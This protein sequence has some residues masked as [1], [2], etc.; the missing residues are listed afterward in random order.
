MNLRDLRLRLRAL[1]ARRRVERELAEELT[2]HIERDVHERVAEGLTREDAL[3]LA[4]S[5]FG[6]T[7]LVA[8]ACR[9]ARGTAFL[10]D[11]LRDVSYA[12]RTYRRAPL[13]ALTVVATIALGLALVTVAFTVYNALFLRG[14]AVRHPEELVTVQRL[15]PD[16]PHPP[17]SN[18]AWMSTTRGELELLRHDTGV[19]TDAAAMMPVIAVRVDGRAADATLVSGNFFQMLG[20]DATRGRTLTPADDDAASARPVLVLSHRALHALF[21]GDLSVIGRQVRVNGRPFDV[22]GVMPEAF[23]GLS[24]TPPDFWAPLGLAAELSPGTA[25]GDNLLIRDV[26]GRM[27]PGLSLEAAETRLTGWASSRTDFR[28]NTAGRPNEISLTPNRGTLWPA[29]FRG[30][31]SPM[32][33]AFGTV[34][35]IGCANV[36]NLLLARGVSRRREIGIRLSL[37]AARRRIVRQLFTESLVLALA[38]AGCGA[39]LSR[40]LL[41]GAIYAA[42]RAMPAEMAERLH[43]APL[44]LD[45][46]VIVL[47]TVAA[48]AATVLFGLAPALGATRLSLVKTV[49]GDVTHEPRPGR[50]RQA[51]IALQ[52]GAAALLLVTST[53]FLRS[54]LAAATVDFG[55]RTNDTLLVPVTHEPMRHTMLEQVSAHPAVAAVAAASWGYPPLTSAQPLDATASRGASSPKAVNY[56]FVS[57]GY[58]TTMGIDI[59]KGRG[60]VANETTTDSGVAVVSETAARRLWPDRQAVGQMVRFETE[61]PPYPKATPAPRSPSRTYRVIGIVHDIGARF[62][63]GSLQFMDPGIY[64]PA[65]LEAPGTSLVLRVR[66]DPDT[67]RRAL[68]DRLVTVDPSLSDISTFRAMARGRV[69]LLRIA[70]WVTVIIAGLALALAASGLFSVL[71]FGV[72]QRKK[73]IGIRLALGASTGNIGRWVLSQTLGP[74][75]VGIIAG[76]G[77]A[78]AFLTVLAGWV[79]YGLGGVDRV[80]DP[81]M[82]TACLLVIVTACALAASVPAWRAA[83]IDPIETLR[84]E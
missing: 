31:I 50:A 49:R 77:L 72:E 64:L 4:R 48:L 38:A 37:G 82:Y 46:R 80:F 84:Q 39:V 18:R 41:A 65:A 40:W 32:F 23:R 83:T 53:V 1:L 12:F 5:R 68:L 54:S 62:A 27:R 58:F 15:R 20:A 44:P 34:L 16:L 69:F 14:D 47:L 66:G 21:A 35:A 57:P 70:F 22:V 52:V 43:V 81:A 19:L 26:I 79:P 63:D 3:T 36:A 67:A 33:F 13:A 2:F 30:L 73:E 24:V 29:S 74:V 28:R 56:Q 55:F 45:W 42:S 76:A 61:P 71:S 51:L 78:T 8:E 11:V 9:D 25:T 59:V 7:P 10:E 75:V 60:F 17:G 6:S